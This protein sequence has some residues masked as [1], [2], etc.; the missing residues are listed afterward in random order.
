MGSRTSLKLWLIES[1]QIPTHFLLNIHFGILTSFLQVVTKS[2]KSLPLHIRLKNK[3]IISQ[4]VLKLQLVSILNI[5]F[6]KI[7]YLLFILK[8]INIQCLIAY[9][10]LS[11]SENE[12]PQ[13]SLKINIW[14]GILDTETSLSSNSGL[15][16]TQVK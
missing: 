13:K 14:F 10:D 7:T 8:S 9:F 1:E 15:I 4:A 2:S 5:E 11:W 16:L 12:N 6:L 3:V